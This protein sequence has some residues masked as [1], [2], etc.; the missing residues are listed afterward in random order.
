MVNLIGLVAIQGVV[1][2]MAAV[3]VLFAASS[4]FR[5]LNKLCHSAATIIDTRHT[6]SNSTT[7]HRPQVLAATSTRL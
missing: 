6:S 7:H 4:L 5:Q 3:G 1:D 2:V